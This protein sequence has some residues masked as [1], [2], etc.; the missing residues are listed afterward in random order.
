MHPD[1]MAIRGVIEN[2]VRA[3]SSGDVP[4][5]M[6]L[7]AEDAI[8][9]TPGQEPMRRDDFAAGFSA[10]MEHVQIEARSD[11]QEIEIANDW[12]WCWNYL[13]VCV[14]PRGAGAQMRRF[15]HTLTIFR[16]EN[17]EWRIARDANLL[18]SG[19]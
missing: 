8:F 19:M 5:L 1:E 3:T 4:E 16:R 6:E 12:A 2:W 17:G 18:G 11:V 15:G 13:D 7:M 14:T 10:A 9:L